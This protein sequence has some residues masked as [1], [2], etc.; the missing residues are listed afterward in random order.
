MAG[1]PMIYPDVVTLI[2]DVEMR[3]L[4]SA[5][6]VGSCRRI[7]RRILTMRQPEA[8]TPEWLA[9]QKRI[10]DRERPDHVVKEMHKGGEP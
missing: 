6:D 1:D 2:N 7:L 4:M 8:R 5:K 9:G 3:E 10:H